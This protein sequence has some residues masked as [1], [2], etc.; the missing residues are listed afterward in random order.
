MTAREQL[1]LGLSLYVESTA[2]GPAMEFGTVTVRVPDHAG[3][4]RLVTVATGSTPHGQGHDTTWAMIAGEVLGLPM[5]DITVVHGDTDRVPAGL[6][7]YASRS[8]QLAGSAIHQACEAVI[9]RARQIAADLLE[10]AVEDTVFD[11]ERGCFHVIGT[12][13][14]TIDWRD[15]AREP[16]AA[17]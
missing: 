14:R 12:P 17:H 7:T 2:A 1:G 9:D 8:V 10:V 4:A 6:G 15:R 11:R 13:S 3:D 16:T 5:D